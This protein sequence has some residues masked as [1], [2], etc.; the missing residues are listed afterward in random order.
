[1]PQRHDAQ[2][3]AQADR[4][5]RLVVLLLVSAVALLLALVLLLAHRRQ[6]ESPDS[7]QSHADETGPVSQGGGSGPGSDSA[8]SERE[9]GGGEGPRPPGDEEQRGA[10]A[11]G[12]G[13]RDAGEPSQGAAQGPPT[14][15]ETR[16]LP[17]PRLGTGDISFRLTWEPAGGDVD[18]HVEDARGHQVGWLI[19]RCSCGAVMDRDD[20]S[21]GG[22]ENIYWAAGKAIRGAYT[23][24]AQ[25][26][27]GE[28]PKTVKLEVRV[29]GKVVES[30]TAV[31]PSP[32]ESTKTYAYE[33]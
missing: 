28:G 20:K 30:Q 19:D 6:V 7:S 33:Y 10:E 24:S 22:P 1:M 5:R 27:S 31:L 23:Y 16:P 32:G 25:Y 9:V 15:P 18:L 14:V 8:G 11:G 29:A 2:E 3:V 21:G 17:E 13:T 12:P 4:R 26:Y